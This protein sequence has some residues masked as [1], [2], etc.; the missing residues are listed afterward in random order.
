MKVNYK[1]SIGTLWKHP[2][3][4]YYARWQD[5]GKNRRKT[6]GTNDEKIAKRRFRNFQRDLVAGKIK[7]IEAEAKKV[8]MFDFIDEMLDYI[9]NSPKPSST[10]ILYK[11]ALTKAKEC[12]GDIPLNLIGTKHID[13]LIKDMYR[14]KLSLPTIN[15]NLRHIKASL[16]KAK[17]WKYIKNEVEFPPFDTEEDEVRFLTK[18][19]LIALME[20]I[21][22]LEFADFCMLSAYTGLRSGELLRLS[23]ID[24]DNP[25]GFLRIS[26]K[27]K[28]KK[29]ARIPINGHARAIINRCLKRRKGALTLFR[30]NT[31]TWISQKFKKYA[32]KAGLK[33]ARFHDLRHT[34]GSHLVMSGK[35]LKVIQELMRHKDIASTMVYAKVSPE[36]LKEASEDLNYGPMPVAKKV[37]K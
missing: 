24:V 12:W 33:E 9:E 26:T 19:A 29:E 21:D 32:L 35:H 4:T 10:Y 13:L 7:P 31:L 25:E 27:Q 8:S 23:P 1:V 20:V 34:F 28:N 37:E 22:D 5:R 3:G 6:L 18:D 2:N 14:A 16:R 36:Y 15:K 30:F 17:K 11:V